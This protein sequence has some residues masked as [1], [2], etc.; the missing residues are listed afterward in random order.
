MFTV[1]R[2]R[3]LSRCFLEF[4]LQPSRLCGSSECPWERQSRRIRSYLGEDTCRAV[5]RRARAESGA[6]SLW[7]TRTGQPCRT[8]AFDDTKIISWLMVGIPQTV[9][10]VARPVR[11]RQVGG[12]VQTRVVSL[13]LWR[14]FW[15]TL[16]S[17]FFKSACCKWYTVLGIKIIYRL[18]WMRPFS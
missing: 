3:K 9:D 18:D 5:P 4:P 1:N 14:R 17:T 16:D 15:N 10:R 2:H 11:P 7:R 12:K 8:R 13:V 6:N